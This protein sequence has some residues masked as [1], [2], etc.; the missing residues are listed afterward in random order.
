LF[1]SVEL[2][3]SKR[4]SRGEVP[5]DERRTNF[6][7]LAA[8][9]TVDVLKKRYGDIAACYRLLAK[10][11]EWLIG[12]GAIEGEQPINVQHAREPNSA[13]PDI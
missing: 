7:A 4:S 2:P 3:I 9:A 6:E 1:R 13:A 12:T 8:T 5:Y 10:E 11:R